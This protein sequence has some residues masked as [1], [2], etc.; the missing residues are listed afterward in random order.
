MRG[1]VILPAGTGKN[2]RVLVFAKG[3]KAKEAEAAGAD[4]VGGDEVVK[5]IQEESWLDFEKVVATPDMMAQVGRIGKIL[6]PRGLMPNPKVGTVTLDVAK[7]VRDI[8]SGKVEFRVDKGGIVHAPIGKASFGLEKLLE[9]A[10]ALI[11]ALLKAKPSAAKGIYLKSIAISTTM[12]H[13]VRVDP[14]AARTAAAAAA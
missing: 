7:A 2:L 3:E 1:T 12:G 11:D 9:N 4:F 5:R 6:G 10:N 13:G 14:L 8:K